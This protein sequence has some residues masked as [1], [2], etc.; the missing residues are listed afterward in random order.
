MRKA[1]GET[2]RQAGKTLPM[3]LSSATG[4]GGIVGCVWV[5]ESVIRRGGDD[6][7]GNGNGGDGDGD[8][9]GGDGDDSGGDGQGGGGVATAAVATA[10][11]MVAMAVVSGGDGGGAP[12]QD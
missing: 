5:V 9:S 3:G 12:V 8:D 1:R 6:D 4:V 11:A 7:D 10:M 2:P